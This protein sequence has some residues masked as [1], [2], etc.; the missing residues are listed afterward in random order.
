MRRPPA[1]AVPWATPQ[2]A[3]SLC[4]GYEVVTVPHSD[5]QRWLLSTTGSN[6]E[7]GEDIRYLPR[8]LADDVP[9]DD[10][11]LYDDDRVAFNLVDPD[12]KLDGMAVTS[13]SGIVAYCR[14]VRNC[15]WQKVIPFANYV[16]GVCAHQ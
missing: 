12:G 15:L 9:V 2:H 3:V 10:W 13:D 11:W 5:Y 1:N 8:H 14:S 4:A 16:D 7:A 6:V